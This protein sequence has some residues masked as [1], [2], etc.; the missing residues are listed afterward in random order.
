MGARAPRGTVHEA[1]REV[2]AG[3]RQGRRRRT[4]RPGP[5]VGLALLVLQVALAPGPGMAGHGAG[6]LVPSWTVEHIKRFLDAGEPVTLIDLRPA[7]AYASG[8]IPGARSIPLGEL[9]Q[10]VSE[11]PRTGRVV[12]YGETVVEAGEGFARLQAHGYRNLS[13]LED[14]FA[15]WRR[16][17]YPVEASR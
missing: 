17:G 2:A 6:G 11:I 12:L 4:P 1:G 5:W 7:P 8:H 3:E 10:R 13:I 15:G 16:R 9:G 14:G